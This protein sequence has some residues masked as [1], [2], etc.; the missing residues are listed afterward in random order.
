MTDEILARIMAMAAAEDCVFL[1]TS[2]VTAKD[3]HSYFFHRPVAHL[4]CYAQDD[5][6]RFFQQAEDFLAEGLYLAG[7]LGYEFGYLLEPSLAKRIHPGYEK[8]LARMG[9]FRKP[10]V[11]APNSGE[12][13]DDFWP[14][15][16]ATQV[17]TDYRL[18]NL[19]PDLSQT[20]YIA[21]LAKIKAGI[22]SKPIGAA[23]VKRVSRQNPNPPTVA[24]SAVE[25]LVIAWPILSCLMPT[26]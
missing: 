17:F 16:S 23:G 9:V 2:R 24:A 5:P 15:S 19:H 12:L 14:D 20:D 18:T 26:N 11:F 4:V 10:L 22:P 3:S 8:P 1:E 25:F 13:P 6:A 21:A 7:W